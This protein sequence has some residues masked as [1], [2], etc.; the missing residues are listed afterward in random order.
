MR[1]NNDMFFDDNGE[2]HYVFRELPEWVWKHISKPTSDMKTL[3][4][5]AWMV[6]KMGC[7]YGICEPHVVISYMGSMHGLGDEAAKYVAYKVHPLSDKS[8]EEFSIWLNT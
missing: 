3:Y 5:L 1:Y 2:E 6:Y 4:G 7:P 8:K